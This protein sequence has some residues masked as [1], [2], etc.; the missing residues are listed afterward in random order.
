MTV[1]NDVVMLVHT[2]AGMTKF[3]VALG[4]VFIAGT[5]PVAACERCTSYFDYQTDTWCKICEYSYCGF[6]SCVVRD[7]GWGYEY[8]DSMWDADGGDE[9]FTGEGVA[10]GRCGPIREPMD[11]RVKPATAPSEWRLVR[12]RIEHRGTKPRIDRRSRS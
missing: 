1:F 10:K 4:L 8:C 3:L 5:I 9:C 6:Y 11:A 12:S 7:S 2:G